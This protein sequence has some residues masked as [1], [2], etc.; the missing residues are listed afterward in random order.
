MDKIITETQRGAG[1][2]KGFWSLLRIYVVVV[3]ILGSFA[4]GVALG[5]NGNGGAT[6]K[7]GAVKNKNA[8]PP[9]YLSKDVD[10]SQFWNVWDTLKTTYLR[11][12]VDDP[13]L[14]YGSIK[15]MVA[16][17]GDPYTV[18]FDPDEASQFSSQLEGT[19]DGIGAEMGFKDLQMIV[20]SPLPNT[21]ASK[22]GLKA[23]DAV[24]KIN[25]EDTKG[26]ALDIAVTKIR[27]PKG[28]KV[29]LNI[30]RDGVADPFDIV[31]TRDKITVDSV[32]SKMIDAAGK[33]MAGN[34]GIALITI[35][36][37]NQ[38]TVK[39]FDAALSA[40]RLR[41]AK[42]VIIDLRG[43]PGGYLDAA[44]E[45]PRDWIGDQPVVIQRKSDG[46]ETSMS[47]TLKSTSINL[48][49][50][51]LVNKWSAS[52]AEIVSGAMQDY[53]KATLVGET[54]FGKGSVQEY[55]DSFPDGSA[56]KVTMA[57]WLTPKGRSIDKKGIT[58]DV[59]VALT[60]DD[61]KAGKDPQ[62]A[63]ALDIVTGKTNAAPAKQ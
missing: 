59:A 12:P 45:V 56:L 54:T 37:F 49:T 52:A 6:V 1:R 9:K 38:D 22:A 40:M 13:K 50:A 20:V 21:P 2:F 8:P 31:I 25:G 28:T 27:G 5:Q 60:D 26:M 32:Q 11:K 35:S 57:E 47:P 48:P 43:D 36:E 46:T 41:G 18:Y 29:T 34:G 7:T 61:I 63:K 19:F 58:P 23:G 14:F 42:A 53:G 24:L 17:L 39:E 10:M 16:S 44:V 51:I 15:G 30:Y 3:L 33:D 62:L 55:I 4:G